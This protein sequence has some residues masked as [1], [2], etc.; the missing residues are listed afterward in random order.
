MYGVVIAL[1]TG[2]RIGELLSI[3][4]ADVDTKRACIRIN[5]TCYDSWCNVDML[6]VLMFPKR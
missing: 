6:S 5:K 2:L 4:W 3:E 1:Y